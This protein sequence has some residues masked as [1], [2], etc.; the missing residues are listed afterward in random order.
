MS[1]SIKYAVL[2]RKKIL[3][4]LAHLKQ[5]AL[6]RVHQGR[7]R[8]GHSEVHSV[9]GVHVS[10]EGREACASLA[11]TP[12]YSTGS[13]THAQMLIDAGTDRLQQ[14]YPRQPGMPARACQP[15]CGSCQQQ[16][17]A[18]KTTDGKNCRQDLW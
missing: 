13:Q 14:R 18:G 10:Q 12:E 15:G 9:K 6:L 2:P 17:C 1:Y 4:E 5:Q 8:G 11:M 3:R 16:M 7:L